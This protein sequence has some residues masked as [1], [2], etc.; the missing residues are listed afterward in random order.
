MIDSNASE[1]KR[2]KSEQIHS[3]I[4]SEKEQESKVAENE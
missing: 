2:T 4:I 1:H 3:D